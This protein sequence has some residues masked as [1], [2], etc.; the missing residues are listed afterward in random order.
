MCNITRSNFVTRFV[1]T[2]GHTLTISNSKALLIAPIATPNL[3]PVTSPCLSCLDPTKQHRTCTCLPDPYRYSKCNA[4]CTFTTYR[5]K[6]VNGLSG[7]CWLSQRRV[8]KEMPLISGPGDDVTVVPWKGTRAWA[9][10][11]R[12]DRSC[13]VA[14]PAGF[15]EK[16]TCDMLVFRIVDEPLE[17]IE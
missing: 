7:V 11:Y 3:K 8:W 1:F 14:W 2:C 17:M 4:D 13:S 15:K 12:H 9:Y 5:L 10:Y 16:I 6:L